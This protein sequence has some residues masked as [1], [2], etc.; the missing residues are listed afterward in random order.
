MVTMQSII[1]VL[2]L[3]VGN[4]GNFILCLSFEENTLWPKLSTTSMNKMI[5][6]LSRLFHF[7]KRLRKES[8]GAIY[9][10]GVERKSY[11]GGAKF[12]VVL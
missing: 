6:F 1:G 7:S 8:L 5:I 12:Q 10:G 11:F 4:C 3:K 9:H 2:L